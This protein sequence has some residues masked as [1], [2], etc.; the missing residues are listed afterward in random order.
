M[1]GPLWGRGG[2]SWFPSAVA[3]AGVTT[4]RHRPQAKKLLDAAELQIPFSAIS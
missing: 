1:C 3:E 2:R 4:A